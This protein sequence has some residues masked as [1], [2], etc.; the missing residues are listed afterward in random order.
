[1]STRGLRIEHALHAL[2]DVQELAVLRE[3]LIGASRPDEEKAWAASR[4]Y[5]TLEKRR[6]DAATLEARIPELVERV[7]TRVEAVF[8]EVAASLEALERGEVA[9][10]ARRFVRAG[11]VEEE[12]RRFAEAEKYFLKGLELGRKPRDRRVEGLAL[13]RLGRVARARA[14]LDR[15]LRCY[16]AGYEVAEA[17][18]DR[19]GVVVA[20]QGMGNVYVDQGLW[21]EAR[22]WLLR[23]LEA[24]SEEASP[25]LRWQLYIGLGVVD[26]RLADI[27]GASIWL[28]RAE[29]ALERLDEP[30]G[31]VYLQNARGR[32]H[33]AREAWPEAE[34]AFRRALAAADEPHARVTILVNLAEALLGQDR[35]GDAERVAREAELEAIRHQLIPKLPDVYRALGTLARVR[36]AEE[37]FVFFEQALEICRAHELPEIETAATE[38]EYARLEMER[39]QWEAAEARLQS[40]RAIYERLGSS[41][42]LNRIQQDFRWLVERS[43]IET[44][45]DS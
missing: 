4:E 19:E 20:C 33:A 2:P 34:E 16:R 36:G 6:I 35:S 42:E 37:G 18:G 32:M 30:T 9:D 21:E 12:W 15:A 38:Y 25:S 3:A 26:F 43:G 14:D 17:Q 7:R 40:A 1:M 31:T 28:D 8:T 44:M 45:E 13:R 27:S 29:T 22:Q 41:P 39:E 5:A 24:L 23:G 11:E 10:A